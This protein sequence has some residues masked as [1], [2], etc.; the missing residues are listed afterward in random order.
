MI[1]LE[2]IV[3]L[4]AIILGARLGG[5]GLGAV[6]GVGVLVFTALFHVPPASPPIDVMLMIAAVVT[7]AGALQAAGGF[8]HLV[9]LAERILRRNPAL[10]TYLGPSVTYVITL[11]AGTGMVAYSL[12]PVIAEVARESG[13]RPERP[14]SASV[15]ASQHAITASPVSP[16]T[17]ALLSII[18]A[19][20]GGGLGVTLVAILKVCIPSTVVGCALAAAVADRIGHELD[21]DPEY[22]RRLATRSA[23]PPT[24]DRQQPAPAVAS[25]DGSARRAGIAVVIFLVSA[26]AVVVLGALPELRPTRESAQGMTRLDMPQLFEAVML[27]AC[28]LILLV[29]KVKVEQIARAS[30]FLAGMQAVIAIFGIAW[31]GETFVQENVAVLGTSIRA[32]VTGAPWSFALALFALSVLLYSQAGTVRTLMPL[33]M[34]IGIPPLALVAMFPAANGYF[35]IPNYPTIVAAIEF[36]RTGTTRVGR[37]VLNHS[38]MLP[39]LVAT[40]GAVAFGHLLIQL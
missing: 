35:F 8:D 5:I 26:L 29:C 38:F 25:D 11:F 36:D 37:Y 27:S 15:I 12:L 24:H 30:V 40:V 7:A 28:A 39:G 10:I 31:L 32:V 20:R 17:L 9:R 3:V 21:E 33:G 34:A 16:A 14:I 6:G 2:L 19:G 13:V 1:W 4:G 22:Q 23:S 18:G